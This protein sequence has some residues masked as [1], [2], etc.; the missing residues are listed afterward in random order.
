MKFKVP[1][2]NKEDATIVVSTVCV[3]IIKLCKRSVLSSVKL[4]PVGRWKK[5]DSFPSNV[6]CHQLWLLSHQSRRKEFRLPSSHSLQTHTVV[7]VH[8]LR[9]NITTHGS[10]LSRCNQGALQAGTFRSLARKRH[11]SRMTW[12]NGRCTT[13]VE[14]FQSLKILK[15]NKRFFFCESVHN[16]QPHNR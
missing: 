5:D 9:P 14:E 13:V 6:F 3:A 11:S 7:S 8:A 15:K 10:Q 16:W 4:H 12:S 2:A 1:L